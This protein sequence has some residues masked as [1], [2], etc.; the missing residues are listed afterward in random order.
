MLRW[1][2]KSYLVSTKLGR[3]SLMKL[4]RDSEEKQNKAGMSLGVRGLDLLG[5]IWDTL[6]ICHAGRIW[7]FY[8]S[9]HIF[10]P[11]LVSG[12]LLD[13]SSSAIHLGTW[14][15]GFVTSLFTKGCCSGL[16]SVGSSFLLTVPSISYRLDWE[17]VCIRFCVFCLLNGTESSELHCFLRLMN[18]LRGVR[19]TLVI[20]PDCEA[21]MYLFLCSSPLLLDRISPHLI[22]SADLIQPCLAQLVRIHYIDNINLCNS[23]IRILY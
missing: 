12:I 4:S 10:Q 14:V 15:E 16:F 9:C 13:V 20:N 11:C 21:L 5:F 2:E 7:V 19:T 23:C 3:N 17:I 1:R 6:E 18:S 8:R 22:Q